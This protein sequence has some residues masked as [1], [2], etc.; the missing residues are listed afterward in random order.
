[1]ASLFAGRRGSGKSQAMRLALL[2]M[3]A[4][5]NV[6]PVVVDLVRNG[7][8]YADLEPLLAWPVITD[9]RTAKAAIQAYRTICDERSK[10]VRRQGLKKVPRYTRDTPLLPFVVDEVQSIVADKDLELEVTRYT[11]ETRPMGGVTL[12]ATQYPHKDNLN[13]T[14]RAQMTNVWAGRLRNATESTVTLGSLP[15]GV[16]PHLLR[17]GPGGS[18]CDVDG[19]DLLTMRGWREPDG[20]GA[21]HVEAVMGRLLHHGP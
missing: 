8:D 14:L 12:I 7:V 15:D 16:A 20:W 4:W 3:V 9:T 5:G 11:Q 2:Q 10:E 6:A 21:A 17:L 13:T 1:M 19:P 18:V